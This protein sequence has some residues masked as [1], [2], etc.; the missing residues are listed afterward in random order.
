MGA[1]RQGQRRPSLRAHAKHRRLVSWRDKCRKYSSSIPVQAVRLFKRIVS[2]MPLSEVLSLWRFKELK[3][4]CTQYNQL[5]RTAEPPNQVPWPVVWLLGHHN[6]KHR[7]CKTRVPRLSEVRED[8]QNFCN[9]LAWRWYLRDVQ[10][11]RCPYIGRSR[12][13]PPC[14]YTLPAP[15]AAWMHDFKST[16]LGAVTVKYNAAKLAYYQGNTHPLHKWALRL[17]RSKSIG[18]CKHDKGG[19]MS[20]MHIDN[21]AIL[22]KRTLLSDEYEYVPKGIDYKAIRGWAGVQA[23]RIGKHMHY[24]GLADDLLRPFFWHGATLAARLTL[25]IKAHKEPGSVVPRPIHGCAGYMLQGLSR[26]VA[27]RLRLHFKKAAEHLIMSG[28]DL[29]KKALKTRLMPQSKLAR[30]DVRDFFTSG[31]HQELLAD[32]VAALQHL[33]APEKEIQIVAG[34]LEGLLHHQYV[35]SP[36]DAK[37]LTFRCTRG[38]GMGIP[39]SGEVMDVAFWWR[40]EKW[41]LAARVNLCFYFY[42]RYR[43]DI[44]IGYG[45]KPLLDVMLQHWSHHLKYFRIKI[46]EVEVVTTHFL[47]VQLTLNNIG[48]RLHVRHQFK[49]K[50]GPPLSPW[51]AHPAWIHREWPLGN[52]RRIRALCPHLHDFKASFQAFEQRFAKHSLPIVWS[53]P[54]RN[55][56]TA[57]SPPKTRNNLWLCMGFHPLL[58][59]CLQS[60]ISQFLRERRRSTAHRFQESSLG[61]MLNEGELHIMISWFNRLAPLS[62]AANTAAKGRSDGESG[63]RCARVIME[64]MQEQLHAP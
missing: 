19:G 22:E 40:A 2:A 50:L 18:I 39:C 28:N 15:L 46:E 31:E 8:I 21:L 62:I 36:L 44:L 10:K 56:A 60:A 64:R 48:T 53:V 42:W 13:T 23:E 61:F 5:S 26:W 9:K 30:L 4:Y 45:S 52:I 34:A 11:E 17:I 25:T 63:W 14:P 12:R 38:S 1:E 6:D 47:E 35:V 51:S 43:D 57:S 59:R 27:S 58:A 20:C 33:G 41:C 24:E 49:D 32:I 29:V 37:K 3:P 7:L 54:S 55:L 16:I